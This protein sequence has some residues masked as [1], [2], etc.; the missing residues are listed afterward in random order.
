MVLLP[1]VTHQRG[2]VSKF[3][4]TETTGVGFLLGVGL[5]VG[6]QVALLSESFVAVGACV[7]PFASMNP[8]VSYQV[9]LL[10]KT[11]FTD[12]ARVRSLG[13]LWMAVL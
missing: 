4:F 10:R 1:D 8:L 3:F 7:G 5:E 6:V 13:C 11:L 12:L 9:A 2:F